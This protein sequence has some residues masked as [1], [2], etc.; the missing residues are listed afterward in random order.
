MYPL[1]GPAKPIPV[2]TPCWWSLLIWKKMKPPLYDE[3][4]EQTTYSSAEYHYPA[5]D[6]RTKQREE[7]STKRVSESPTTSNTR[8]DETL[9]NDVDSVLV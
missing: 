7:H 4:V 1:L 9:G 2:T 3:I 8:Y 6:T 5:E